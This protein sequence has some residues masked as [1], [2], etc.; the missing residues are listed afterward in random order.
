M[1]RRATW[2]EKPSLWAGEFQG[3]PMDSDVSIIFTCLDEPGGGPRLHRHPYSETF[4]V[5]HGVV[6][7]SDGEQSFEAHAGQIIVVPANA[8]HRF[9][10]R[11]DRLEMIDVHASPTFI[12]EWL[13]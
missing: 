4:I 13:D 7:F 2:T 10:G 11:S 3:S 5:R 9:T 1:A 6:E 12:T 8:P